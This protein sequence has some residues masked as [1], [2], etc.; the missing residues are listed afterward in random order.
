M[1]SLNVLPNTRSS[2][3]GRPSNLERSAVRST[4]S[5]DELIHRLDVVGVVVVEGSSGCPTLALVEEGPAH[6]RCAREEARRATAAAPDLADLVQPLRARPCISI[7]V[8]EG[9]ERRVVALIAVAAGTT[10][11]IILMV[12]GLESKMPVT[13]GGPFESRVV[14]REEFRAKRRFVNGAATTTLEGG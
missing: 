10:I 5:R 11:I 7:A 2:F 3:A 12:I 9:G 6:R 14:P 4:V 8:E 1:W 13:S